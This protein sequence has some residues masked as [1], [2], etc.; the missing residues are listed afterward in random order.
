M[1]ELSAQRQ[2]G[3]SRKT[4]RKFSKRK[5]CGQMSAESAWRFVISDV[6][7]TNTTGATKAIAAAIRRL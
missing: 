2:S 3:A 1:N 6:R 7:T 4:S 5:G